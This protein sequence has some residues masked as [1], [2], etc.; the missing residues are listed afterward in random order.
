MRRVWYMYTCVAGLIDVCD[1][2]HSHVRHDSSATWL[3]CVTWLIHALDMIRSHVGH[4][5][6]TCRTWLIHSWL[7]WCLFP[8]YV[9]HDSCMYV[10]RWMHM[11]DMTYSCVLKRDPYI[12]VTWLMHT[13][14]ITRTYEIRSLRWSVVKCVTHTNEPWLSCALGHASFVC[15]TWLIH[16]RDM[17]NAH[18]WHDPCNATFSCAGTWCIRA[19]CIIYAYV[20]HDQYIYVT[21]LSDTWHDLFI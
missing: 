17:A 19:Q 20:W 3:T 9:R 15:V 5:S 21:W 8:T 13:C 14:E 7:I 1:T 16:I 6:F 18:V 10:M 12:C 11:C 2:I 4:D